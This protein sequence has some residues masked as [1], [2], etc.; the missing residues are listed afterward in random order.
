MGPREGCRFTTTLVTESSKMLPTISGPGESSTRSMT[1]QAAL[2]VQ[3]ATTTMTVLQT[4][5]TPEPRASY[6][7][8]TTKRMGSSSRARALQE[9][10][11]HA[12]LEQELATESR[13]AG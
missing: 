8:Y 12:A 9:A 2:A 5:H 6:K 11:Q 1:S 4:S 3:W 13:L 7:A 10:P